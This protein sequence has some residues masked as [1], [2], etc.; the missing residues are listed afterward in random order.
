MTTAVVIPV[1]RDHAALASLLARIDAWTIRPD[2]IVVVAADLDPTAA[3]AFVARGVR[4]LH[5]RANRGAQLDA[6]ARAASSEVLC[7]LHAD[8]QPHP[9]ALGAIA[10]AVAAGA[11]SGCFRFRFAGERGLPQVLLEALIRLRIGLGGMAYGD[12]GVFATRD[13]YHETGGFAHTPL[14][15]EAP[16]LRELRRRGTFVALDLPLL[17]SP[18][19]WQRDGWWR[20]TLHNRW[21]ATCYML[22]VSPEK[23]ARRYRPQPAPTL[24]TK[25]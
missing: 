14:F 8:S 13:A 1:Y 16:L 9:D 21:L 19:R 10:A 6:G 15:E 12:Q 24:E 20:R 22:G 5:G 25:R 4:V 3:A 23:L 11:E 7:F 17:V 2:E 18:R